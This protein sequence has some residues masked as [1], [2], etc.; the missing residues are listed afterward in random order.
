MSKGPAAGMGAGRNMTLGRCVCVCVCVCEEAGQFR[1]TDLLVQT[2]AAVQGRGLR[3]GRVCGCVY[4]W[5]A[6]QF[7][8]TDL[9]VQ[10][11]R[12]HERAGLHQQRRQVSLRPSLARST[13]C[14]CGRFESLLSPLLSSC[15]LCSTLLSPPLLPRFPSAAPPRSTS[16]F[17]PR[18]FRSLAVTCM[19][20]FLYLPCLPRS[21]NPLPSVSCCLPVP[22]CCPVSCVHLSLLPPSAFLLPLCPVY[23]YLCP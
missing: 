6:G 15:L 8:V 13:L 17:A 14:E 16:T 1:G 18:R 3:A 19:M 23:I 10:P 20:S 2:V 12:L 11:L 9:L 7:R 5:R 4:V 22:F 21:H